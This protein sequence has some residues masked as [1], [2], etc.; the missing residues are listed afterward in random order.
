MID[1]AENRLDRMIQ[2]AEET[3]MSLDDIVRTVGRADQ[4]TFEAFSDNPS[5]R[6]MYTKS[7]VTP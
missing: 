6:P 2:I 5:R 1:D 7:R 3:G 4:R